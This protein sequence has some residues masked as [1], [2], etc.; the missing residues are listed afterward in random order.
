MEGLQG[1]FNRKVPLS[2][3]CAVTEDATHFCAFRLPVE[4]LQRQ[5]CNEALS[6]I[7]SP[8][9]TSPFSQKLYLSHVWRESA[10]RHNAQREIENAAR[11]KNRVI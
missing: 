5:G 7:Q 1:R 2:K 8:S 4:N 9:G 11:D 6:L 10:L 3:R